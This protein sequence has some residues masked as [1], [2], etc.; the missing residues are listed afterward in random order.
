MQAGNPCEHATHYM[1]DALTQGGEQLPPQHPCRH[2]TTHLQP[3]CCSAQCQSPLCWLAPRW[4]RGAAWRQHAPAGSAWRWA[5]AGAGQCA[6]LPCGCTA[7]PSLPAH[8]ESRQFMIF[9]KVRQH[10]SHHSSVV[11]RRTVLATE[12]TLVCIKHLWC[13][14]TRSGMVA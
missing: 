4:Q 3:C 8:H 14:Q 11:L 12:Q 2:L 1:T 13:V 9:Q 7:P 6:G 5:R 10:K